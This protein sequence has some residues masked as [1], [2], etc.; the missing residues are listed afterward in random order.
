[1]VRECVEWVERMGS[2]A[3][4]MLR[5]A[6]CTGLASVLAIAHAHAQQQ[7]RSPASAPQPANQQSRDRMLIEAKEMVYNNDRNTVEAVGNVQIFYQGR[8]LEADRIVYNRTTKRVFADG[9]ARLTEANGQVVTGSRFEL[10]DDFR[11]GFIDTLRTENPDRSRFAAPRAE[12]SGG[13]TVSFQTGTY[14]ACEPCKDNPEKPP[15]WQVRSQRIIHKG[16]E[17]TIYFE[18]SRLEFLGVPIAYVPYF[19]SP[20][21][22]VKRQTGLLAP[23]VYSSNALG[24]GVGVPVFINLAPNYDLTLTPTVFSRQGFLGIAEW[25][26][27]VTNGSYTIR[28]AGIFPSDR[29]AFAAPPVGAGGKSFRG[30]I[31]TFGNFDINRNWRFGWDVAGATDRYFFQNYRLRVHGLTA[32]FFREITSQAY[33]NGQSANAWFD[34]RAYHFRPLN[35]IDWQKQQAIVHPVV[36]Y[37]RRFDGPAGLGGEFSLTA[38]VTSL[39]REQAAFQTIPTPGTDAASGKTPFASRY[40]VNEPNASYY[41]G[42]YLYRR[43]ECVLRGIAG[44]VSRASVEASWRRRIFDPIGQ[45]WTPFASI[46]ADAFGVQLK[47]S[48]GF[49]NSFQ[50]AFGAQDGSFHRVMPAI[51]LNYE[52]PFLLSGLGNHVISPVAQIVARPSESNI[53]RTPNEDSQS[54]FFDDTNLFAL[55]RFSGFD[56]TEGGVRVAYGLNYSGTHTNGWHTNAMFGQSHQLSGR[57]S[58]AIRDIGV[59][60]ADTGLDKRTS[61]YVARMQFIPSS[62]FSLTAKGRFDDRNFTPRTID[63]TAGF[64]LNPV[65]LSATYARYE[66]QP[67]QGFPFRREGLVLGSGLRLTENWSARASAFYNLGKRVQDQLVNNNFNTPRWALSTL[68]V[69]LNYRDECTVFDVSYITAFQDSSEGTRRRTNQAIMF[70]LELRTLGAVNFRQA[71]GEQSSTGGIDGVGR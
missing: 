62:M 42:C 71:L 27:R 65:S 57:N 69:G 4:R 63:V 8:T 18:S 67:Q 36:D 39:T 60:G 49:N 9:N 6:A 17:K 25:R 53:L 70:R 68:G 37:N 64:N 44:T 13:D 40:L 38:N 1:M 52:Y 56:R 11:E 14:T 59:S 45:V 23:T 5:L 10:T 30:M 12:R 34:A 50:A 35:F 29:N 28:G 21:A 20:D 31:E 3:K 55:N 2:H 32:T 16:D 15:L 22:T 48:G 66:P 43:G 54:V 41:E 33:L 61:D 26:H 7:A 46:R 24:Y 47:D 51:G 58:Y 19:W